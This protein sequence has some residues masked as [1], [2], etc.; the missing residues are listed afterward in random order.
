M[1][2]AASTEFFS[3]NGWLKSCLP[4]NPDGTPS[5]VNPD[6]VCDNRCAQITYKGKT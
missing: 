3:K 2:A 6:R 5:Y 4:N 1:S